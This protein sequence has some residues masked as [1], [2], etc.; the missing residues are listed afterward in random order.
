MGR[1][2]WNKKQEAD[3]LKNVSIS[4]LRKHG[5][6]VEGWR[7][8]RITWSRH[9]EETGNI[10]IQS[11]IN[12]HEQYVR[13]IYSQTNRDTGEKT[14][15]DYNISLTTTACFLGGKRYWFVCPWYVN[16]T[17]CGR[18]VGMVYLGTK[19]FACRHCHNL[20]YNSRNLGGISKTMGQTI[21]FPELEKLENEVKRKHYAGK[22]TRRYMRYLNKYDKSNRQM[23]I[24]ARHFGGDKR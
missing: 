20:T 7:S 19:H 9:G 12:E 23:M 24:M 11:S 4:F 15:Y 6:L 22:I 3:G 2:Y 14:E 17:Y 18:R 21:S 10:S 16:S 5:Y 1:Y 8:G 13:F